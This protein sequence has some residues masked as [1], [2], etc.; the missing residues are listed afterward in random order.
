MRLIKKSIQLAEGD[1]EDLFKYL[2]KKAGLRDFF[3]RVA[4]RKGMSF[5][6]SQTIFEMVSNRLTEPR[7]K[8]RY[9]VG[10]SDGGQRRY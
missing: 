7:S 5:D 6:L 10:T 3:R 1:G 4:K 8:R 9:K 2:W